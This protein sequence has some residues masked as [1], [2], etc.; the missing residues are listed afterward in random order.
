MC[1]NTKRI[2][3]GKGHVYDL[4]HGYDGD[5]SKRMGYYL[6][7]GDHKLC[8]QIVRHIDRLRRYFLQ[9]Y[10]L[11]TDLN[12]DNI[13]LQKVSPTKT[14]L[15]II[16][17]VDYNNRIPVLEYFSAIGR[18]R[19]IRKW[20]KFRDEKIREFPSPGEKMKKFSEEN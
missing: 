13:L 20:N 4:V 17:G 12:E 11:F 15:I 2:G 6:N 10:I 9:E 18:K 7:L 19:Q 14:K 1:Q 8:S 3:G 5:I 16:D